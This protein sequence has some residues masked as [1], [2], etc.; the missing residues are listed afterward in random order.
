MK[1]AEM[2]R[3][4]PARVDLDHDLLARVVEAA[5]TCSQVCTACADA[6]LSEDGVADLRRCIRIDLDCADV[7]ATTVRV[8][9]RHTAYE[10]AIT[11]AVLQA[12]VTACLTCAAECEQHAGMHEHCRVCAEACRACEELCRELLTTIA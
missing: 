1:V 8:L 3:T 5:A 12:C 11:R 2:I 7:C 4:T 9:S 6:C 10:A